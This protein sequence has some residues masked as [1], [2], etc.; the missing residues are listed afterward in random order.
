MNTSVF[1]HESLEI[2]NSRDTELQAFTTSSLDLCMY[3]GEC[4]TMQAIDMFIVP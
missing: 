2:E 3:S 4:Y 1:R